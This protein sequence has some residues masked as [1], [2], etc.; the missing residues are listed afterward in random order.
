[1]SLLDWH[2][3]KFN[4]YTFKIKFVYI[5]MPNRNAINYQFSNAQQIITKF[6]IRSVFTIADLL[7]A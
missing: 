5:S 2:L 7:N 4:R 3:I 6:I 1:M